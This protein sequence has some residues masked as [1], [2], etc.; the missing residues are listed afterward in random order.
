MG[1]VG[2][3]SGT[4]GHHPKGVGDFFQGGIE[5][6]SI[7]W[8]RDVGADPPHGTGPGKFSAQGRQADYRE[9]AKGTLGWGIVVPTAGD[10]NVAGGI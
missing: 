4:G 8:F 10:S 2:E 1:T 9:A 5:G 7:I 6:G 3:N